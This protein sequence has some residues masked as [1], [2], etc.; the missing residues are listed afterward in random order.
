M[1]SKKH[2]A[3]MLI[4]LLFSLTL[5][6]CNPFS[7]DEEDVKITIT[8]EYDSGVGYYNIMINNTFLGDD[9]PVDTVV[10][11][12][13]H[14]VSWTRKYYG[15]IDDKNHSGTINV[16]EDGEVFVIDFGEITKR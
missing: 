13:Y 15:L 12:G 7:S 8:D 9:L 5:V 16:E 1:I 4:V 10:E 11:T 3:I 2:I 14:T 6:G